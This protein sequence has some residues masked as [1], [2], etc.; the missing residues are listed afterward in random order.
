MPFIQAITSPKSQKLLNFFQFFRLLKMQTTDNQ[1]FST[2]ENGKISGCR[3]DYP[4][5]P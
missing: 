2:F 5:T 4:A 3:G 1:K